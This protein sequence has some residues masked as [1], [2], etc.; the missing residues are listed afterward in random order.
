LIEAE[1]EVEVEVEADVEGTSGLPI[2]NIYCNT[3]ET[4]HYG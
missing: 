4:G 1:V 3:D 2:S